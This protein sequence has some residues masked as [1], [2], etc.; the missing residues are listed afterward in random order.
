MSSS[1][2][3][4]IHLLGDPYH[5]P[6]EG[7]AV[8]ATPHRGADDSGKGVHVAARVAALAGAGEILA[9]SETLAESGE[10][11][12]SDTR[13]TAVKSVSTPVSLANVVWD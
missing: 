12:T 11:A 5:S 9:T 8:A 10:L 3:S 13:T 1:F 6:D 2:Q 7:R 4:T